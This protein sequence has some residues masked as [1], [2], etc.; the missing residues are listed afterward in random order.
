VV[1]A[2]S[3]LMAVRDGGKFLV[4]ALQSLADQTFTDYEVILVDNNSR[5]GSDRIMAAWAE[6]DARLRFHR[7][8]SLGLARCLNFAATHARA[9]LLARLDGDDVLYPD[10]FLLQHARL[11]QQPDLGLLGAC[12][13]L[14]DKDDNVIGRRALLL[15]DTELRQFLRKGNPFVH[16]TIMMRR[17]VFEA[18][19][20]YRASLRLCEDYDLWCRMSEITQMANDP[21]ILARYRVHESSMSTVPIRLAIVDACIIAASRAREHGRPEPFASGRPHLRAALALLDVPRDEFKYRVLKNMVGIARLALARGDVALARSLRRRARR[22]L[23]GLSLGNVSR[24]LARIVASHF[25]AGSR[26]RRRATLTRVFGASASE[27]K[28]R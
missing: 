12:V 18:T 25:A 1:P 24:G 4:P 16:S 8:K 15:G 2:I 22:Q 11:T 5:D 28:E 21:N 13:D 14:I 10:R 26:Q 9:P 19:G 17:S 23:R 27:P 7:C 6:K 3:V 20:G